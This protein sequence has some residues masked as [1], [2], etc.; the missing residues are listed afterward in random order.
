MSY[1]I[2]VTKQIECKLA[3][4]SGANY[5]AIRMLRLKFIGTT[6]EEK[7]SIIQEF[8]LI[9]EYKEITDLKIRKEAYVDSYLRVKHSYEAA[10]AE[11]NNNVKL[12]EKTLNDLETEIKNVNEKLA[13]KDSEAITIKDYYEK[14]VTLIFEE[15]PAA[16]FDEINIAEVNKAYNDFF[17]IL[18]GSIKDTTKN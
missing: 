4:T 16:K 8:K 11:K 10:A 7:F 15:K 13:Q 2:F 9:D 1:K 14:L 3:V 12:L 17:L 5:E 18:T 6:T